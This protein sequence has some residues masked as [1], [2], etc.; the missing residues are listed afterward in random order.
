MPIL[1]TDRLQSV[2]KYADEYVKRNGETGVNVGYVYELI[3]KGKLQTV[4]IDGVVFIV[5]PAATAATGTDG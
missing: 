3:G 4:K 5:L 2:R 1:D